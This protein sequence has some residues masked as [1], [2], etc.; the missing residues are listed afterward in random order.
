MGSRGHRLRPSQLGP[1]RLP[2]A[3]ASRGAWVDPASRRVAPAR[4]LCQ[5]VTDDRPVDRTHA[6]GVQ[7]QG[8]RVGLPVLPRGAGQHVATHPARRRQPGQ[9]APR[10]G[11][12]QTFAAVGGGRGAAGKAVR[13]VRV[14][15]VSS[16]APPAPATGSAN[17]LMPPEDRTRRRR[18]AYRGG[19]VV[20]G[21]ARVRT[22]GWQTPGPG[23]PDHPHVEGRIDA[24]GPGGPGV[25]TPGPQGTESDR[26][27]DR[28]PVGQSSAPSIRSACTVRRSCLR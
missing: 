16:V 4:G 25:V 27:P 23:R 9:A 21:A 6:T 28:C 8:R 12:P 20:P 10:R 24:A 3:A 2:T 15:L 22:P 17:G 11:P 19:D 14:L 18:R 1:R 7:R 5:D 13:T 26:K